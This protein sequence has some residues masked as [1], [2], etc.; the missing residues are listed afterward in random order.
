MKFNNVIYLSKIFR[1]V[2]IMSER[3]SNWRFILLW[4]IPFIW[5]MSTLI[6]AIKG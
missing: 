3:L 1:E 6:S 5:V 2:R 4:L